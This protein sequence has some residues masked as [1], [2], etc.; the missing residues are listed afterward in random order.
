M[1]P[2]FEQNA[3]EAPLRPEGF[4]AAGQRK[5]FGSDPHPACPPL[6]P[7]LPLTLAEME[8]LL[9]EPVVDLGA[10]AEVAKRDASLTAQLLLLANR[11]REESDRFYRIED[12]VVQL[13]ISALQELVQET[14]P[15][16]PSDWRCSALLNHSRLTGLVAEAIALQVPGVDSEK[17]YLAGLLHLFPELALLETWAAEKRGTISAESEEWP[18]PAFIWEVIRWFKHPFA[19]PGP[20]NLLCEV[21][22]AACEWV[23][24]AALEPI[25]E[26]LAGLNSHLTKAP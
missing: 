23:G 11:D 17:A 15:L 12:C 21:V 22:L 20:E 25:P 3:S 16:L 6:L 4:R 2:R 1:Q 7:A 5:Q 24:Q 19:V 14:P 13:G 10:I 18:L 8:L 9:Q 26:S